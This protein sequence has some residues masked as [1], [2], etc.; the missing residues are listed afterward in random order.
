[1]IFDAEG[2]KQG[3]DRRCLVCGKLSP[4]IIC[5]NCEIRIQAEAIDHK[6]RTEKGL[7][8]P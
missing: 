7:Q 5:A 1:M 8:Q 3:E 2:V 6:T 4:D